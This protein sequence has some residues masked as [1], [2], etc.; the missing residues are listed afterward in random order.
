MTKE[1]SSPTI[2]LAIPTYLRELVLLDT[3]EQ[4]LAQDPRP[5]EILVV[6]QTPEHEPQTEMALKNWHDSGKLRWIRHAPPSLPGARNRAL[7]ET[8][9]D[10]ILFIDDDVVLPKDFVRQHL[11]NYKDPDVAAIGGRVVQENWKPP[12][13]P[14]RRWPPIM[15]SAFLDR[16]STR[17]LIGV[18]GV[19]GG[20]HSVR[21]SVLRQIGGYDENYNIG[22]AIREESDVA[23]R[24]WKAHHRIDFDPEAWLLHLSAPAGGCRPNSALQPWMLAFSPLYF[25]FRHLYPGYWFWEHLCFRIPRSYVFCKQNVLRP[26]RLP[27]ALAAYIEAMVR[28]GRVARRESDSHDRERPLTGSIGY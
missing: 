27:G 9:C 7:R 25:A 4:A 10:V 28:A 11:K 20:N 13:R 26:W 8:N 22:P 2:C 24:L 14:R 17:R 23:A 16:A 18:G 1:N 19:P 3:I 6:D 15:D 21:V 5:D 12:P